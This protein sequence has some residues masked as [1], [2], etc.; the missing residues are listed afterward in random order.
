ISNNRTIVFSPP[1][2]LWVPTTAD[3]QQLFWVKPIS[4]KNTSKRYSRFVE[5]ITVSSN[6]PLYTG[7]HWSNYTNVFHDLVDSVE[8]HPYRKPP[9]LIERLILNHTIAGDTVLDPFGGSGVVEEVCARLHR[10]SITI[11]KED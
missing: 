11:E 4:T 1:E 10:N 5:C 2:N 7:R 8:R 6:V 9:S 3:F